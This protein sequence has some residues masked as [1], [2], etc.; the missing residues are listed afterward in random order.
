MIL[1]LFSPAS[2]LYRS[3]G[4]MMHIVSTKSSWPVKRFVVTWWKHNTKSMLRFLYL[5]KR[6]WT[7]VYAVSGII[8]TLLAGQPLI[9]LGPTSFMVIITGALYRVKNTCP[10]FNWFLNSSFLFIMSLIG[11]QT[12]VWSMPNCN[13]C[14]MFL[15]VGNYT[16]H[17]AIS[18][19]VWMGWHLVMLVSPCPGGYG[20][21]H[22]GE[23]VLFFQ[24]LTRIF[25][26]DACLHCHFLS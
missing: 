13:E 6:D 9:L 23:N 20:G 22:W 18:S 11:D 1:G 5:V 14:F 2:W 21:Q 12:W 16:G 26:A 3:L 4:I 8:Y 17:G 15:F 19:C 24:V 25:F 7:T 10:Q